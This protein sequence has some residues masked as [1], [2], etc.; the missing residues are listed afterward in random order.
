MTI[1]TR[2]GAVLAADDVSKPGGYGDQND[3]GPDVCGP[4][5][6]NQAALMRS[7]VFPKE[8]RELI[9]AFFF[10]S[11]GGL[12]LHFRLHPSSQSMFFWIPAAFGL[13]STLV[14]PVLFLKQDTVAYAYLFTWAA[15]IAG[16][17]TMAYFSITSWNMAITVETVVLKSTLADIIILWAKI[18]IAHKMLRFHWPNG[19]KRRWERGCLQ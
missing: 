6:L 18:F 19:V 5:G 4:D 17:V 7:T 9:L 11:L 15:V 13:I 2:V 16:T 8:I 3:E 14:V 1:P 10:I 12:F